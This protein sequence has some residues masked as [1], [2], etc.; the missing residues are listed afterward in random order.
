MAFYPKRN[1]RLS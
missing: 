1:M